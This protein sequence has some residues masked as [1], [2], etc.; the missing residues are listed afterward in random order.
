MSRY[1]VRAFSADDLDEATRLLTERHRQQRRTILALDR[2][3]EE[4]ASAREQVAALLTQDRASGAIVSV[5]GR[6]IGW[7]KAEPVSLSWFHN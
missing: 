4:P 5:V 1:E 6:A 7:R 3:Y 2:K